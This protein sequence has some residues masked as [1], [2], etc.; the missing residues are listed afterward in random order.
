[1]DIQD[2]LQVADHLIYTHTGK[3]LDNLQER[4][5]KETLQ[6]RKYA[7]IAE[8]LNYTEGYI[9]DVASELWKTLSD[10]L[11][12]NISKSNTIKDLFGGNVRA[13]L[14]YQP[15]FLTEESKMLIAQQLNH[16]SPIEQQILLKIDQAADSISIPQL[17]QISE[18]GISDTLNG[19]QSLKRRSFIEI[20]QQEDHTNLTIWPVIREICNRDN[21][22]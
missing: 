4:I 12:E 11:G 5:L 18:I 20:S 21:F 19:L 9:K 13:F 14:P 2:I 10:I 1:M 22:N 6:G 16:L 7:T 17:L 3:H 15:L 8:D